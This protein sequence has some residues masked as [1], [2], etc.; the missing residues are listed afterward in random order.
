[1][2]WLLAVLLLLTGPVSARAAGAL[3]IDG[4]GATFPGPLYQKWFYV[5]HQLHPDLAIDYQP[6]GSGAGIRQIELRTVDFG[7]T[8]LPMK[9]AA[10]AAHPD[11]VHIPTVVGAIAVV[12]HLPGVKALRL[13]PQSLAGIFLGRITRWNAKEISADNPGVSL[14]DR[15]IV[16]LHRSDGSGT[17]GVFTDY[18]SK[19]SSAWRTKVGRG[20][21]V[22]WPV[23]LGGKGNEGVAAF[24]EII[25]GAIG[26]VELSFADQLHFTR[27]ALRNH[28]GSWVLPTVATTSAAAAQVKLPADFRT[29]ITDA[30]GPTA[31][32]ISS[33]TY[34]LIPQ[35]QTNARKGTALIHFLDWALHDGQKLAPS[36]D[37]APL[38]EDVVSKVEARVHAL[39]VGG[40]PVTP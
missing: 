26:Y 1:M 7:A 38:P 37:Y 9:D 28:D 13:S 16:V 29:S 25:P 11:L 17:T 21:S 40:H 36:L 19:V 4:A 8:D 35:N 24:L 30:P 18:L 23:G 22:E 33:F 10:L 14:P 15:A 20:K 31:Y 6:L 2:R 27:A 32:P 34:L 39:R 12:F 3:R 5:Y